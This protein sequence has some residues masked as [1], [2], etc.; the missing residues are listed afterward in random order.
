[1]ADEQ[2]TL[3]ALLAR[4]Q[5][6]EREIVNVDEETTKLVIFVIGKDWFAFHG[7]QIKEIISHSEVYELPGAPAA[8]EGVINLR[9]DIESV[10][11]LRQVL[12]YPPALPDSPSRILLAQ[13][14]NMRS[15]IRVDRVE[16]VI[17][18]VVSA[19]HEPPHTIPERLRP[20]VLGN[21]EFTGEVVSILDLNRLL[22]DYCAGGVGG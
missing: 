2:P 17:D 7:E 3:E 16:E 10:F 11:S 22:A 15:G 20:L 21:L 4:Q 12:S 14:D 13:G 1:M 8:L 18:V 5:H 9:G 19:I 6:D